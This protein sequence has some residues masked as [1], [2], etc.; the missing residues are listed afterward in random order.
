MFLLFLI[1]FLPLIEFVGSGIVAKHIGIGLS[2]LWVIADVI[3]GFFILMTSGGKLLHRA[4]E[5]INDDIYPFEEMYDGFCII[6]GAGLLI[7]PGFVSDI[8]AVPLLVPA[9][10]G[11]IFRF[12]KSQ[13][14]SLLGELSKSSQG[15]TSWYYKETTRTPDGTTT[16]EGTFRTTDDDKTLPPQN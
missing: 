2:L 9:I 5:S 13:H 15:F 16:I 14:N 3:I 10:R 1:I 11:W 4:K 7:F 8:L 6:V 12:L